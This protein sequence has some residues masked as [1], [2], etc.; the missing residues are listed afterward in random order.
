MNYIGL[1][2]FTLNLTLVKAFIRNPIITDRALRAASPSIPSGILV[3]IVEP[4]TDGTAPCKMN[5]AQDLSSV[6]KQHK[7]VVLFAVPGYNSFE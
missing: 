6:L 2:L 1:F 5:E 7:K 3:D 4:I